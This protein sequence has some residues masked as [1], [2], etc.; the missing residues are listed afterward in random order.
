MTGEKSSEKIPVQR[1][2]RTGR[3]GL[4]RSHRSSPEK[5]LHSGPH[6]GRAIAS[7]KGS[8]RTL[9]PKRKTSDAGIPRDTAGGSG[10][11][12]RLPAVTGRQVIQFL[13]SLGFRQSRQHGSHV[14]LQHADGRAGAPG[15]RSG[16]GIDE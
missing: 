13:E 12:S 10:G 9:H 16:A 1:V 3:G 8:Y 2:D 5:L 4:F 6:P 14:F 11:M 7:G 15:G